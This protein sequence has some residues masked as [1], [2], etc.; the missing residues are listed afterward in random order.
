MRPATAA[1]ALV[2]IS[3]LLL[4]PA[5]ASTRARPL[6]R[7]TTAKLAPGV[8]YRRI[9]NRSVPLITHV[10]TVVPEKAATI[11]LTM[12]GNTFGRDT[13]TSNIGKANNALA[14]I[15]GDFSDDGMP[16]HPFS[17]D[18]DLLTS[19]LHNGASFAIRKD[20]A[21]S[22]AGDAKAR[23]TALNQANGRSFDIERWN[24]GSPR[25]SE[26]AGFTAVGA[27]VQR[28][29]TGACSVRL[30]PAG[31]Y[32]WGPGG[33]GLQRTYTVEQ[34]RCQSERMALGGGQVLAADRD[35]SGSNL[36]EALVPG[37]SIDLTWTVEDWAG[38]AESIGGGPQLLRS[39]QIVTN[40]NCGYYFCDRNPR[41]GVGYANDGRV[42]LVV[43]DGRSSSSRGV[44][45]VGFAQVFKSLGATWALNLD[46]G[47]SATMYVN[48]K[49]VVNRPSDGQERP[50]TN[51]VLVLPN[52]DASEPSVAA[53]SNLLPASPSQAARA[54]EAR[55]AD[56]AS[57]GG[58]LDAFPDG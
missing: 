21:R 20:E 24:A 54:D 34:V 49:G 29:P 26:I 55:L 1:A 2:L 45:L 36:I 18:G 58:F 39:G 40:D 15:N 32:R 28:P 46:G 33:R 42:F 35:S 43:V 3:G 30:F 16:L 27:D 13:I 44:S 12:A 50:A 5:G 6:S 31:G 4:A 25:G 52:R 17:Q 37:G 41:T 22:Y 10:V 11:D 56:P 48:G 9:V 53:R 14:A 57:T 47:G 38:V 19:G 7:T 51:A 8:T 23:V